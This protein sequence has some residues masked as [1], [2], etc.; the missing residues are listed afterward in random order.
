MQ[1]VLI[2]DGKAV[3]FTKVIANNRSRLE[4][5]SGERQV[6]PVEFDI[7]DNLIVTVPIDAFSIYEKN[8]LLIDGEEIDVGFLFKNYKLDLS[9]VNDEFYMTRS[10]VNAASREY[11]KDEIFFVA[12]NAL[13]V[14]KKDNHFF[15][16]LITL[17]CYRV[18][19]QPDSRGWIVDSLFEE[20]RKF[21]NSEITLT[22]N[23]SRWIISSSC[24][25]GMV[26]LLKG[27]IFAA[28]EVLKSSLENADP[29]MNQ[30]C[31]WNHSLCLFMIALIETYQGDFVSSGWKYIKVFDFSRKAINDLYHS[32]NDWL[33][34]QVSD[35]KALLSIGELAVKCASK[36][37][38]N[39]PAE[40]RIAAIKYNGNINLNPIFERSRDARKLA[41]ESFFQEVE[42]KLNEAR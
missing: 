2:K 13:R 26:L 5:F 8:S 6:S 11:N 29:E 31:Y 38:G 30:L 37:L 34:G 42:K 20:K 19:E 25:L 40:S 15:G 41:N 27:E 21:D 1:N 32:R 22:P 3:I 28:N 23:R 33:L 18:L 36:C 17:L 39:I 4:F 10:L 35:C 14:V 7:K 9:K 12:L 16:A 24:T